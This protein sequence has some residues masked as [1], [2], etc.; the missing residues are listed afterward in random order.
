MNVM[1]DEY[2][3]SDEV[4]V[5]VIRFKRVDPS[6]RLPALCEPLDLERG[7]EHVVPLGD[8]IA[9]CSQKVLI[10]PKLFDQC[11]NE[12]SVIWVGFHQRIE[13]IFKLFY[14]D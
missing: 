2:P 11:V 4:P 5:F 12:A 9:Q 6:A 13:L 14:R 3:E 8:L 7:V 1:A 10:S